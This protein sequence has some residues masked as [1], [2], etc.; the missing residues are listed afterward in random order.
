MSVVK[1]YIISLGEGTVVGNPVFCELEM[2]LTGSYNTNQ[3]SFWTQLANSLVTRV[4]TTLAEGGQGS[5]H[6]IRVEELTS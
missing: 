2:K 5:S 1:R 3:A 6:V 4:Q